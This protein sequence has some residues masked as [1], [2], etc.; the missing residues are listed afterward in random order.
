MISAATRS[1]QTTGL[2]LQITHHPDGTHTLRLMGIGA[3]SKGL[4][5]DPQ[6][7]FTTAEVTAFLAG[8]HAH[9]FDAPAYTA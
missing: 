1:G 3:Q 2:P 5:R 6:L 7:Q 8:I 9:E 4:T